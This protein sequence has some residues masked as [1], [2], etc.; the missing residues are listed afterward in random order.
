MPLE[1]EAR[2]IWIHAAAI[3]FDTRIS[4]FPP[5]STVMVTRVAPASM[6][7]STSSLTTSGAFD[8]LAGGDLVGEVLSRDAAHQSQPGGGTRRR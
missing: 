5:C 2:V 4:F 8:D 7:F 3:V 6:A 1:A